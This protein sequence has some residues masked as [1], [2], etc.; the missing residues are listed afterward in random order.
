MPMAQILTQSVIVM[1]LC[2]LAA[3]ACGFMGYRLQK[4]VIALAVF[5]AGFVLFQRISAQFLPYAGA[6]TGIAIVMACIAAALSFHLYL[7]GIFVAF[8]VLAVSVGRIWIS[9]PWI[10]MFV[11]LVVGC[12]LGALAVHM[13]RPI[14]I[15]V[16][17]IAGGFSAAQY[18]AGLMMALLPL[19]TP[20]DEA[21][22]A[23]GALLAV[24][25]VVTQFRTSREIVGK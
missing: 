2:F 23:A 1:A 22:L 14:V 13:N 24:V 17:G 25:G 4:A 8:V 7:A 21:L 9:N 15:L 19:P 11:G 20:T 10:A 18:G 3:L 16:T 5:I 12:V 6:A